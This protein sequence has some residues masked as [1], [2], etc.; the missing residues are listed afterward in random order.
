MNKVLIVFAHPRFEKSRAN[1]ALLSGVDG[2][3]GVTLNDLYEEYP[4]FNIASDRE[5]ALLADHSAVVWHFP[6]YMYGA[7]ALFKHWMDVV[8]EYG[9]AHG[10]KGTAL[11]GKTV[12]VAL[13]AGGTRE[14]YAADQYNRF[15]LREFLRPFEQ[16]AVLCRMT[17]LPPFAVHGTHLLTDG[18]LAGYAALYGKLLKMLVAGGLDAD[19]V[20]RCDYLNDWLTDQGR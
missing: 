5:Q 11:V 12:F 7:P 9:W 19:A 15:A 4:D 17:W 10:G 6:I 16:T 2:I 3:E 18:Q 14:S 1:R 13:T 20:R 8:L